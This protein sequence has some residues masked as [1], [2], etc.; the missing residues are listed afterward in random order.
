MITSG[1]VLD[2]SVIGRDLPVVGGVYTMGVYLQ[3]LEST[4][5]DSTWEPIGFQVLL[6]QILSAPGLVDK[7]SLFP[8]SLQCSYL[9]WLVI[10][11]YPNILGHFL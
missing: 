9:D 7:V 6:P 1:V 4:K 11:C 8:H 3:K 5:S 2:L 10:V